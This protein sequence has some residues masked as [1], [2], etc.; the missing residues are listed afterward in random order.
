MRYVEDY[1]PGIVECRFCDADCRTHA[2]IG[3]LPCFT[4]ANLS[5]DSEFPHPGEAECRVLGS[6]AD[7]RVR[8][9]LAEETTGGTYEVVVPEIDLIP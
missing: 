5:S 1:F 8:I 2:M 3:K 9:A 4:A 6:P 7:G